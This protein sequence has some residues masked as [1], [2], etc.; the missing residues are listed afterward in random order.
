MSRWEPNTRERLLD[1]ALDLFGERGYDSVT[2]AE[3][4]E[5]AGLTKRTFFRHFS[6]KREVL[7]AGQEILSRF[8][9]EAI[10]DAPAAAT[11]IE[12]VTAAL[13]A[14]TTPFGPHRRE[15]ARQVRAVVAGHTD[16]RERELLKLATLRAAMADALRARGVP[17]P[18]ATLAAEIGGL[19]FSAGFA[20]WVA[21]DCEREFADL[22]REALAELMAAT[23]TLG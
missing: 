9:A 20:R 11:P 2:V 5:R 22:V 14:A 15:R 1:A 13:V 18:T 8:F 23:A 12:A 7:F 4:A 16:L 6:D 21:P 17:A 10:A 19:A 3:I